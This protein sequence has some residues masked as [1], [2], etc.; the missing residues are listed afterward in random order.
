VPSHRH[1]RWHAPDARRSRRHGSGVSGQRGY[2]PEQFERDA[3]S[4]L[5]S[6]LLP[7]LPGFAG[8]LGAGEGGVARHVAK[9]GMPEEMVPVRM[10]ENPAITGMPSPSRSSASWLR[11][12]PSIPGS[13]RVNPCSPRTAMALLKTTRSAGP[14]R[15]RPPDSASVHSF[16]LPSGSDRASEDD[17]NVDRPSTRHRVSQIFLPSRVKGETYGDQALWGTGNRRGASR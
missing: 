3:R 6:H 13:I 11:S 10:V 9:P 14:R 4:A 17:L 15:R 2:E 16:R 1:C 7:L 8:G 12:E 5:D